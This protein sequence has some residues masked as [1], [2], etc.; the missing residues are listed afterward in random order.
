MGINKDCIN[1]DLE[2]VFL[3]VNGVYDAIDPF[4]MNVCMEI[5]NL[6]KQFE[7]LCVVENCPKTDIFMGILKKLAVRR[8][9]KMKVKS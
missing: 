8:L 2:F 5:D 9:E 3:F 4:H 7:I 6:I 1:F